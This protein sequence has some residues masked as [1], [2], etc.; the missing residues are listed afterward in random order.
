MNKTILYAKTFS[1]YW[2]AVNNEPLSMKTNSVEA[3]WY[4]CPR[5]YATSLMPKSRTG[6]LCESFPHSSPYS[7]RPSEV[8]VDST[9]TYPQTIHITFFRCP[10]FQLICVRA[11]CNLQLMACK[12]LNQPRLIFGEL[13]A[14]LPKSIFF[15]LLSKMTDP[16]EN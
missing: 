3:H 8:N 12:L 15:C 9:W 10:R 11:N 6:N 7:F 1:I 14:Y 4:S 5:Y 13:S 16:V 2:C